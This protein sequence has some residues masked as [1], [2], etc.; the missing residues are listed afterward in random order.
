MTAQES[1]TTADN[2]DIC[3]LAIIYRKYFKRFSSTEIFRL[4]LGMAFSPHM[5]R[6]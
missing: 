6:N 3:A 1:Y 4:G 2:D 5:R